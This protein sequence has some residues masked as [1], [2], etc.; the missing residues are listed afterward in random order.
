MSEENSP[1]E[2]KGDAVED[3]SISPF[4]HFKEVIHNKAGLW[5]RTKSA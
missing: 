5:K 3:G 1:N 4:A 2:W